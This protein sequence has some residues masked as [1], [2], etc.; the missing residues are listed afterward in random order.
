MSNDRTEKRHTASRR[1]LH[2]GCLAAGLLAAGMAWA[3]DYAHA[4][5][6]RSGDAWIDRQ[7]G[8]INRY[9][10]RYRGAFIDELVRYH[11]APRELATELLTK[12][13]WA[14]GDVYYA[15]AV[16]Q[17]TGRPCRVVVDA[18]AVDHA[19]GWE[20]VAQQAGGVDA[21]D[22]TAR[23]KQ[24]ITASYARW[25]RPLATPA[26]NVASARVGKKKPAKKI[27]SKRAAATK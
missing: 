3:Q 14:P 10:D 27:E 15:C 17:S 4:W 25:G 18:W 16:A 8:D 23:L 21:A 2:I 7:L 22:A 24:D 13:N 11:A 9:G 20:A 26:G 19:Q 6:P 12:R 5:N 1:W